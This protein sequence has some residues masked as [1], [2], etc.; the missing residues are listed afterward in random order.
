MGV[1]KYCLINSLEILKF[2]LVICFFLGMEFRKEKWSYI[3]VPVL[4]LCFSIFAEYYRGNILIV[5]LFFIMAVMRILF[6]EKMGKLAIICL[7]L[8]SVIGVFD[9][10]GKTIVWILTDTVGEQTFRV[11]VLASGITISCILIVTAFIKRRTGGNKIKIQISYY[12]FFSLLGLVN[13]LIMGYTLF[14]FEN[15]GEDTSFYFPVL[16]EAVCMYI[17]MGMVLVLVVSRDEYREKDRLNQKYLKW[18][19]EHYK[20]LQDKEEDTRKFRHDVSDHMIVLKELGEKERYEE[21]KDYIGE[22]MSHLHMAD[23]KVKVGN[24]IVDA[25]INQYLFLSEQEGV[26]LKISGRFSE[27]DK[28]ESYDLCV[29]FS[30]LLRNAIEAAKESERK[31]AK[32]SISHTEEE[33]LIRMQNDYQGKRQKEKGTYKTTKAEKENSGFGLQ[34]IRRSVKKY[35]GIMKMEEKNGQFTVIISIRR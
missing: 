28:F 11:D 13:S 9:E 19:E 10:I 21:M 15:M 26:D 33:L 29:I 18:Q 34:N 30:N 3:G 4:L 27:N 35:R 32:L 31:R 12:V 2:V 24:G 20:Y 17:Q 6:Q 16:M 22:I 25:I 23:N 7:L 8:A 5:Y 1:L 14:L